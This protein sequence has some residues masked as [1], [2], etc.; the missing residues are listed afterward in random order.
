MHPGHCMEIIEDCAECAVRQQGYFCNLPPEALAGFE[1]IKY[2]TLFPKGSILFVEGLA[3]RGVFLL[4]TGRVKLSTYSSDGK[5]LITQIVEAGELL[6]LS[7][8][9]SGKPYEVTAE[10]LTPCQVNFIRRADFLR[11]LSEHGLACLRAAEHLSNSY[12]NSYQQVRSLGLSRSAGEK[13][14][15][16]ILDWCAR[17]G[18]PSDQG[19][20]VKLTLTHEEIAQ[21]IGASRET[22]TRLLSEF[23]GKKLIRLKGSH[24]VVPDP[25]ALESLVT[26]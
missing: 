13:L 7:A 5:A 15:K 17:S 23:R 25:A 12:H 9:I 11:Y 21:L 6:G 22:V 26:S 8:S 1:E 16:L 3:P 2:A 18:R 19:V 20:L 14:A 10:T 24:L 4:C